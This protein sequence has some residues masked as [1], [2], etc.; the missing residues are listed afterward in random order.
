MI[1]SSWEP[2]NCHD[3]P[4][5]A[6]A[7]PRRAMTVPYHAMITRGEYHDA[8]V[9]A[10]PRHDN[11]TASHDCAISRHGNPWGIPWHP[12]GVVMAC[13]VTPWQPAGNTKTRRDKCKKSTCP[14]PSNNREPPFRRKIWPDTL[15]KGHF[16][17]NRTLCDHIIIYSK[18]HLFT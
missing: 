8:P 10:M 1:P 2:M 18:L 14:Q 4:W 12:S 13:H 15:S 9:R 7:T 11:A 16:V 3:V 17:V 5:H 6:M